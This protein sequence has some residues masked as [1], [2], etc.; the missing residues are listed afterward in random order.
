MGDVASKLRKAAYADEFRQTFGKDA[1]DDDVR[2]FKWLTLALEYFQRDPKEFYPYTSKFDASLRGQVTLSDKE[3]RG[4]K[5]FNDKD[6]GNCASCHTS[7]YERA[8]PLPTFTDFGLIALGVPRNP[9]LPSNK[10]ASFY[11][12]GLC[13]PYRADMASHQEYCGAFRTPSLRNVALRKAFFH[14]GGMHDLHDVVAFYATRD[15]DPAR[16]YPRVRTGPNKGKVDMYNDLPAAVRKNVNHE[17]PFSPAEDGSPRLNKEE[18][19]DIVAFLNTL[20]DGYA[21]PSKQTAS[22]QR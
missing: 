8:G 4:L 18:I 21:A 3:Q 22:A 19:D 14:N 2:A 11:D 10:Q 5:W 6:K 16:W 17:A 20:T 13:G 1:L 7:R 9:S 15:T 12:M